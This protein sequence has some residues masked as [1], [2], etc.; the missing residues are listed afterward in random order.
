[1]TER[2]RLAAVIGWPVAQ[3]VSPLMH[4]FWLKQHGI[5]G[6]YIALPV[7]PENFSQC[8]GI[9]PLMGFA[10]V[11]VFV[12]LGIGW[13]LYAIRPIQN[14]KEEDV[15][16]SAVPTVYGWL[17]HR[18]YFDELYDATLLKWYAALAWLADWLDRRVWGGIVAAVSDGFRGLGVV[19]KSVDSHWID[20]TFDKG[21]EE[22]VTGG[23]V[24][25]WMQAQRAP[26]Y[27]RVLAFG[28]LLLAGLALMIGAATGQ[29]RL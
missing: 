29:V 21:C 6:A 24:L 12:G 4:N 26:G 15:L 7:A 10:I 14:A 3:S 13:W 18:L 19:N 16:E 2:A 17:A 23:G 25:A 11:L 20:G 27:L 28:V 5:K 9:L 22:L 8:I 1:V